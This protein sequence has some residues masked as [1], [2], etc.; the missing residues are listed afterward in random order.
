MFLRKENKKVKMPFV[1]AVPF[2]ENCSSQNIETIQTCK[3]CGSHNISH[4]LFDS[5]S[6]KQEYE[7]KEINIHICDICGKEFEQKQSNQC[8]SYV[9]GEFC[10]GEYDDPDKVYH[11]S[12]DL[13]DECLDI[14]IQKLNN[15]IIKIT[16]D[17]N[18]F[19]IIKDK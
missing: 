10:K 17:S 3:D 8:I 11:I 6:N 15:E 19:K 12:E 2:C 14:K 13:C 7:T 4:D 18:V 16:E 9:Y 5:R 1:R